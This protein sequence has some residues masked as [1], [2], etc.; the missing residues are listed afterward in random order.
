MAHYQQVLDS[1]TYSSTSE[2]PTNFGADTSRTV[3]WIVNDGDAQ[4]PAADH[5]GHYHGSRRRRRCS[6]MWRRLPPIAR[7]RPRRHCRR[8]PTVSDP[9]NQPGLGNGVD[10]QRLADRR[11]AGGVDDR[12]QHHRELQRLDRR[13]EPDRQ[14]HAG[15]LPAGARQR[16]LLLDQPEPDQFRRR[17][18]PNRLVDGQ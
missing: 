9:D 4:Q 14:R 17:S 5:H 8:A 13:A 2:N 15:A 16:H 10:H 1:V 12:H 3:S 11:Y 18:E 7:V 6:A